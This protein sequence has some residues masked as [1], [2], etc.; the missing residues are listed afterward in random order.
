MIIRTQF[1]SILLLVWACQGYGIDRQSLIGK[2]LGWISKT[3]AVGFFEKHI[4][5]KINQFAQKSMGYGDE[6]ASDMYQALGKEAQNGVGIP[7]DQQVP[8]KRLNPES[9]IVKLLKPGAL[10]EPNA[11][12]VNEERFKD[13]AMEFRKRSF[14]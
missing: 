10:A 13:Q 1:L 7:L 5:T 6:P 11:I 4:Q 9:A 14:S 3:R 12:F 8:I 2:A